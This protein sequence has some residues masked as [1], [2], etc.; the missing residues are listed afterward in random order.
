MS[1]KSG[2]DL[3]F[4]TNTGEKVQHIG[5]ELER[6][7]EFFGKKFAITP[8]LNRKQI[9]TTVAKV[10]SEVDVRATASFMTHSLSV[11]QSTYQQ[12]GR[13]QETVDRYGLNQT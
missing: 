7:A 13:A 2:A 3:V 5:V 9:A 11:H 6:L 1:P 4:T 12:Q 8:T 10:G